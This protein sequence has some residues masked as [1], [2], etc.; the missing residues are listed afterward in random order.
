MKSESSNRDQFSHLVDI[1]FLQ[2]NQRELSSVSQSTSDFYNVT[3]A[4]RVQYQHLYAA[5]L[6]QFVISTLRVQSSLI[7]FYRYS[8]EFLLDAEFND[9]RK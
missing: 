2:C 9:I 4:S 6:V 5:S 1:Q 7:R 3:N 8:D